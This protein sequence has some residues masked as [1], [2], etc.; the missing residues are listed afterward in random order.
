MAYLTWPGLIAP[1]LG[2]PVGGFI[3]TYASWRWIFFLNLP[4]GV[5]ALVLTARFVANDRGEKRPPFDA[6]G[7]VLTAVA[8]TSLMYGFELFGQP[9]THWGEAGAFAAVGVSVGVAAVRHARR[10]RHPMVDLS[11]LRVPTFAVAILGGSLFRI[12]IGTVPFLLPLLLQVGFG[13]SAFDSGLLILALFAGNLAIKPLTTP[14][15]RRFGFRSVLIVNGLLN[16]ATILACA[17]LSFDTPRPIMIAVFFVGG[18]C[19]SLQFTCLATLSFSDIPP[20]QMSGA[21]TFSS[22]VQQLT[23]GMGI[24]FGALALHAAMLLHGAVSATPEVADFRIAFGLIALLAIAG[25]VDCIPLD[26]RAGAHVSGHQGRKKALL[27]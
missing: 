12:A 11:G 7:F 26:R 9:H 17:M 15:L 27:F 5:I 6:L 14:I 3:T 4:L 23:M 22:T 1:V 19:R 20:P 24:A 25:V 16:A 8:L 18:L 2:P 13:L 21:S 10:H